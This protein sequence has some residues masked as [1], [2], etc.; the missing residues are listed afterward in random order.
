MSERKLHDA[1]HR[2]CKVCDRAACSS[3][4]GCRVGSLSLLVFPDKVML[5][6]ARLF[7][8]SPLDSQ[9]RSF[10]ATPPRRHS[11][12]RSAHRFPPVRSGGP[13]RL[14]V[15]SR[16]LRGPVRCI[17][18]ASGLRPSRGQAALKE[19]APVL[20]RVGGV[21]SLQAFETS[22]EE[23]N[24]ARNQEHCV[25]PF[26]ALPFS[27]SWHPTTKSATWML[28]FVGLCFAWM[29]VQPWLS[30]KSSTARRL[31]AKSC[32]DRWC[33]FQPISTAADGVG[34]CLGP[35]GYSGGRG[36]RRRSGR[37]SL[38]IRHG[39]RLFFGWCQQH[40]DIIRL[41]LQ[42]GVQTRSGTRSHPPSR[43]QTGHVGDGQTLVKCDYVFCHRAFDLT[44]TS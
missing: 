15:V 9:L 18:E 5:G 6:F 8:L 16:L 19:R 27:S 35:K 41:N 39:H 14:L 12:L 37:R 23:A 32:S 10:N 7:A 38:R 30:C 25:Y 36:R 3:V 31:W 43:S 4:V 28:R 26:A 11:P 20:L 29:T 34:D 2:N 33:C 44:R 17:A 13:V 21:Q 42:D 40:Q 1:I 22:L 24:T